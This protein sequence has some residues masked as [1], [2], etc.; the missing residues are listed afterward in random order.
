V[1]P[2]P[3]PG[4]AGGGPYTGLVSVVSVP[5]E[6]HR[7][8]N[9]LR[10]V[11]SPDTRIPI[12]AVNLWYAVG[13]MH[14]HPGKTGFAHLFEHMMFQGSN[15]L[16]KGE[17]FRLIQSV[18]G[19]RNASTDLDRTNYYEEV[20]SHELELPIWLEAERMANLLPAMTQ[21]KLDNQ[22]AV[23]K[24][25]RRSNV[26][27]VPYGTWDEKLQELLF[28]EWHPYHHGVY[29]SMEDLSAATLED[30]TDFFAAHYCPNNAVL[31][32][33]GDFEPDTA[34]AMIARHFG[35]IPANAKVPAP[36]VIDL[37]QIRIGSEVREVLQGQVS[38]PRV[39]LAYRI[40][41]FGTDE[42]DALV[43]AADLLTAGRASRLY[44]ALVRERQVAQDVGAFQFPFVGGASMLSIW[45]TAASTVEPSWLESE[46]LA[47]IDRLADA[48]P[49][50]E[51][52]IRVRN[53]HG[54]ANASLLE[55]S[56]ERADRLGQ[57][58]CLFDQPERINTKH[59]RYEAVT[60]NRVRA[61]MASVM[62]PDNRVVLT[63]VPAER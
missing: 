11:L 27:N 34:L 32:V 44:D 53:L 40:P 58:T 22:R 30:V 62:R 35:P 37:D 38:L 17:H 31:T 48:G 1:A 55:R 4:L 25:E 15:N 9:G 39:Y 19:R 42:F 7:L 43:V 13:S 56:R 24:N 45:A 60:A 21:E 33:A 12:V 16:A 63:Y 20:P 18:G 14:E 41:T 29:G 23:V 6:R 26:D 10:V 59:A 8:E 57:Y 54:A 46:L 28:P 5:I 51:E 47:E 36:P 49:D 61:A 52:L 50:E 2:P 3:G